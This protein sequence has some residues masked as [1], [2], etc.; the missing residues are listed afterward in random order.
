MT[1]LY[2]AHLQWHPGVRCHYC[3]AVLGKPG[4]NLP[5]SF[6]RD[7]IVPRSRGGSNSASN[8]VPACRACNLDKGN[9][10]VEEWRRA[11]AMR[12]FPRFTPEQTQWL[13][14]RGFQFPKPAP[15]FFW[16]ERDTLE[17]MLS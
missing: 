15:V 10:L 6:S 17:F 1:R 14:A 5:H 12:Q 11:R 16:F 8:L 4:R 9:M 2:A 3:G 7:H 13:E